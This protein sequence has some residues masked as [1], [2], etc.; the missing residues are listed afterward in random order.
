MM[1]TRGVNLAGP[2]AGR[3]LVDILKPAG[4]GR[5]FANLAR[6]RAKKSI[7]CAAEEETIVEI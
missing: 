2:N 3:A 7:K 5:S 4:P 6:I 1:Y